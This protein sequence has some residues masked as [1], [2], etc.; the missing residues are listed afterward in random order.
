MIAYSIKTKRLPTNGMVINN[1]SN[2]FKMIAYDKDL[3]YSVSD[4]DN[5]ERLTSDVFN[6]YSS[7]VSFNNQLDLNVNNAFSF[8][9][10][11]ISDHIEIKTSKDFR[12]RNIYDE[13]E[14]WNNKYKLDSSS[15]SI[16][17]ICDKV[18]K[19]LGQLEKQKIVKKTSSNLKKNYY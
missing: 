11:F 6:T 3:F 9:D 1:S 7:L 17:Q 2:G 12:C 8:L 13:M 16:K 5:Q 18:Q 19:L 10:K 14:Y 4:Y 15:E